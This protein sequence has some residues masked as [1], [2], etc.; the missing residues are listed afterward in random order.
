MYLF[1][2]RVLFVLV[3]ALGLGLAI[4]LGAARSGQA[5]ARDR[6]N[7]KTVAL[8]VQRVGPPRYV[9]TSDRRVHVVYNLFVT[10]SFVGDVTLKRLRIKSQGKALQDLGPKEFAAHTHPILRESVNLS[11]LTPST[12]AMVLVDIPLRRGD[13]VPSSLNHR[14]SYSLPKDFP[15]NAVIDSTV[16]LGPRLRV[17]TRPAVKIA[18]PLRGSGWWA[19]GGCCNPDQRHRGALLTGNGTFF[20]S[21]MF[22]IDWLQ[23]QNGGIFSGDGKSLTDYYGYGKKIYAV[24]PGRVVSVTNDRPEAPLD[25]PNENLDGAD[26]F[27]GNK[28][29][30]RMARNMYQFYGHFQPG[31]VRVRRGQRVQSGKVLGLLGNSGN[32]SAPHLHFG[33]HDGPVPATSNSLPFRIDHYRYQGS[34][35]FDEKDGTVPLKGKHRNERNTYP[36]NLSAQRYE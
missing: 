19:G 7:G 20:T 5:D 24:A 28:V 32:S 1:R 9:R 3:V 33:I 17:P 16:A 4:V 35:D 11:V 34:A 30:I 22:D 31:S 15:A 23:V 26:S 29:I 2:T 18:S 21:E 6:G 12:S 25:G 27:A 10:N 14:I 8:H 13:R 36:L